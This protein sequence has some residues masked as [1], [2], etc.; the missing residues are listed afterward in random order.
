MKTIPTRPGKDYTLRHLDVQNPDGTWGQWVSDPTKSGGKIPTQAFIS[1]VFAAPEG[2]PADY[3][4]ARE[5]SVLFQGGAGLARRLPVGGDVYGTRADI[6]TLAFWMLSHTGNPAE[7][8]GAIA[9]SGPL[10]E[11]VNPLA[12]TP[13]Q[14]ALFAGGIITSVEYDRVLEL[15]DLYAVE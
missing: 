1:H 7:G 11:D 9:P 5:N 13:E 8:Y 2:A 15:L 12:L 3:T 10:P 4:W 14:S 6:A